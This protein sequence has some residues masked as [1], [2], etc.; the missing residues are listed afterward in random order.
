MCRVFG[1]VA[2]EPVSV[3]HELLEA[4]NPLIQQSEEHDSGW[5]M[6]VYKRG[7]GEDPRCLRF[8]EPAFETDEFVE[9]TGLRGRIFNVHVRRATMGGLTPE[10]THPFC[11]GPYSFCHNGTIVNYT[12]LLEPGV[13]QPKGET[14]SEAFFN[15][16]MRDFDD[17]HPRRSMR[18]AVRKLIERSPFSG[19]N[20]LFSDG[21]KLYAYKLGIFGLHWAARPGS[22]V[23]ASERL[24]ATDRWHSVHDDVLVVLDPAQLD[25]PHAERLVGDTW[26]ERADIQRADGDKSLRGGERGAF[27]AERAAKLTAESG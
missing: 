20:F 15:F 23:V 5:G 9:A 11:L 21:Y 24:T 27:A 16:L 19:I 6:A 10:N 22:L 25:A 2:A 7:E 17:G 4:E 13:P 18:I 1:C 8:P 14:D 26:L 12:K 3:R